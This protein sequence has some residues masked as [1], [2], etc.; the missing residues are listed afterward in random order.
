MIV[1]LDIALS[2]PGIAICIA[3]LR[4]PRPTYR[5]TLRVPRVITDAVT[6]DSTYRL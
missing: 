3:I 4:G 2:L 5:R 6:L 1:A